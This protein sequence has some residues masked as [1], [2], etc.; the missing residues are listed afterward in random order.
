MGIVGSVK[1]IPDLCA[2][3]S[4]FIKGEKSA[5]LAY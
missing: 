3:G 1:I 5:L 4:C 2:V